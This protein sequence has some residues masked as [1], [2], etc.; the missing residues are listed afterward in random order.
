[1]NE[2]LVYDMVKPYIMNNAISNKVYYVFI[3]KWIFVFWLMR[4]GYEI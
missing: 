1:M 4:S 2:K 3:A